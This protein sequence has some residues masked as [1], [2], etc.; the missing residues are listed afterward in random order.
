MLPSLISVLQQVRSIIL[1]ISVSLPSNFHFP[2]YFLFLFI[3]APSHH[4]I[5]LQTIHSTPTSAPNG[6]A[7]VDETVGAEEIDATKSGGEGVSQTPDEPFTEEYITSD[8]EQRSMTIP[9]G[10][11]MSP[12]SKARRKTP[13]ALPCPLW[14]MRRCKLPC[15][16]QQIHFKLDKSF[17]WICSGFKSC[18]GIK[19]GVVKIS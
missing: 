2:L 5:F 18:R 12:S 15:A 17:N 1:V 8:L 6:T 4:I 19:Q 3:S 11:T 16:F 9:T 14:Q 10:T 7:Q 13:L